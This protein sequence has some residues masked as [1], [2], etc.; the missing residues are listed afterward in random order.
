MLVLALASGAC[1]EPLVT[2]DYRGEPLLT[3]EGR[4]ITDAEATRSA[5]VSSGELKVAVFWTRKIGASGLARLDGGVDEQQVVTRSAF[6]ARYAMTLYRP[7]EDAVLWTV[8]QGTGRLGVALLLLY[9]DENL[10][11]RWDRTDEP[12]AGGSSA[13]VLAWAEGEVR[14]SLV[15]GRLSAGYHLMEIGQTDTCL[16][17]VDLALMRA[18]AVDTDIDLTITDEVTEVMPDADCDGFVDVCGEFLV[19]LET[20]PPEVQ[21]ELLAQWRACVTGIW[22]RESVC[23]DGTPDPACAR[24]PTML[25]PDEQV[26]DSLLRAADLACQDGACYD[27]HRRAFELCLSPDLRQR[28]AEPVAQLLAH[29]PDGD[30]AATEALTRCL[31]E[32]D[33]LPQDDC[34]QQAHVAC[35]PL[36]GPD[37]AAMVPD[38]QRWQDFERCLD[39]S[40]RSCGPPPG[41]PAL[42]ECDPLVARAESCPDATCFERAMDALQSCEGGT[43]DPSHAYLCEWWFWQPNG[44]DRANTCDRDAAF[45]DCQH[46][47]GFA[48]EDGD[49]TAEACD[50]ICVRWRQAGAD[51]NDPDVGELQRCGASGWG[52]Q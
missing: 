31:L 5:F 15:G 42:A 20:L 2:G 33:P 52:C 24:D 22:D 27:A 34:L 32:A 43:L 49:L 1:S 4:I 17:G 6:P 12:L 44:C 10:N 26:C 19:E 39:E 11:G 25:G 21:G 28:C 48:P 30:L 9:W 7:P 38:D 13:Y 3:V 23:P 37:P 35:E 16:A 50:A 29:G 41:D 14:S 47:Y 36:L 51:P 18:A 40:G 8:P 45:L 46:R